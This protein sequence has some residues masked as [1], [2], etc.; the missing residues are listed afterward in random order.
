[1]SKLK[2]LFY[3]SEKD[4]VKYRRVK[5]WEL[6]LGLSHRATA[7]MFFMLMGYARYNS[8][9]GWRGAEM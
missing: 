6:V 7:T 8:T 1:M 3:A 9:P 4:G 5:N 2:G